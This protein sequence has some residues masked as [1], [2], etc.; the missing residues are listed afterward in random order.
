MNIG[1]YD[2]L[3]ERILREAGVPGTTHERLKSELASWASSRGYTKVFSSFQS[4][5]TPDV[6]RSTP[7]RIYL[8][9]GDAKDSSNETPDN[10]ETLQRIWSYIQE[11][12]ALLADPRYKGGL[13]AI[14]TDNRQ[15]T[16]A[17]VIALNTLARMAGITESSGSPPSFN[18]IETSPGKTWITYW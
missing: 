3:I 4:G 7:D 9:V 1:K 11:F 5:A 8:F 17:W 10:T 16:S 6:L 18:V 14:A 2:K 12:A 13:I 15:A